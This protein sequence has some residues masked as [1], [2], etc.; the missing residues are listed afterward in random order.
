MTSELDDSTAM[1]SNYQFITAMS[2]CLTD[3]EDFQT[4]VAAKLLKTQA[5]SSQ[6]MWA[7]A[8]RDGVTLGDEAAVND[9]H[10]TLSQSES[11]SLSPAALIQIK[12]RVMKGLGAAIEAKITDSPDE[13]MSPL[14][15]RPWYGFWIL[16]AEKTTG[17]PKVKGTGSGERVVTAANAVAGFVSS[18]QMARAAIFLIRMINARSEL[19]TRTSPTSRR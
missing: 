14:F 15:A 18:W 13:G 7:H 4:S 19:Q 9:L 10:N 12:E 11:F 3:A 5:D 17:G 8:T 2:K 16:L 6:S 1:V